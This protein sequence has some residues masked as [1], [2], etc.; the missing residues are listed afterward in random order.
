M[1]QKGRK[2]LSIAVRLPEFPMRAQ[3]VAAAVGAAR[4]LNI[5]KQVAGLQAVGQANDD[6]NRGQ[7]GSAAPA[8]AQVQQ[9]LQAQQFRIVA[10]RTFYQN[11][12][13]WVEAELPPASGPEPIRIRFNSPEWFALL[14]LDPLAPQWLSTGRQMRL[15]LGDKVYEI[16]E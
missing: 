9:K 1:S 8:A 3:Y 4:S 14:D 5:L 15:R 16:F 6:F 7:T 2:S 12:E 11:R 10:N 13:Q